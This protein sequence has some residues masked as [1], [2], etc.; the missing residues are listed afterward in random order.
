MKRLAIVAYS[1][2][3]LK[4]YCDLFRRTLKDYVTI[5]GYC[6]EDGSVYTEIDADLVL[7]SSDDMFQIARKQ[8]LPDTRIVRANL[9]FSRKGYE[10]IQALPK[11]TKALLVNVNMNLSLQCVEQL[12]HLGIRDIELIPYAPYVE[13]KEKAEVAISPGERWSVPVYVKKIIEVG[14]RQIDIATVVY[15]LVTMD[16]GFL[17]QSPAIQAYCREIIPANYGSTYQYIDEHRGKDE[18]ESRGLITFN[19]V[20]KIKTYNALAKEIFGIQGEEMVG[21]DV[22]RLFPKEEIRQSVMNMKPGQ[23]KRYQIQGREVLI[24]LYLERFQQDGVLNYM[25]AE[26]VPEGK[27]KHRVPGRGYTAKYWFPDIITQSERMKNLLDLAEKNAKSESSILICGESGTGKELLAQ[28]IHNG[29]S[30]KNRPFVGLNCASLPESLLESELFGYE[31][32]AF[33]GAVRGGKRGLF[34]QANTG[35]LFLDEIGEMPIHLQTRLLRVL[36]EKE[37][38]R[39]GGE[40]VIDVDVRIIAATNRNLKQQLE[41]GSFRRDLYYRLNVIPLKLPALRERPEDIPLLIDTFLRQLGVSYRFTPE[42]MDFLQTYRWEGNIRELRNCVEYFSNWNQEEISRKDLDSLFEPEEEE[43][44]KQEERP[45]EAFLDFVLH[46]KQEAALSFLVL[47]QIRLRAAQGQA[48]G[49]RSL[50]DEPALKSQGCTEAKLRGVL[51]E[52]ERFGLLE[53]S[54]GRGGTSLTEKGWEMAELLKGYLKTQ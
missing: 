2:S 11:G 44:G 10:A 38:M 18:V 20:G 3:A 31:E 52:L 29:S 41:E 47:E 15:V 27:V 49:R 40:C 45:P 19:G 50:V 1:K 34:E 7:V 32:G 36:Q 21:E 54:R 28:S 22:I 30:R 46:T 24:Q 6:M 23:K 17:F 12:Y 26:Y 43:T 39:I 16:L 9:T 13:V 5:C 51:Q 4:D 53:T 8:V 14:K 25:T 37:I 33:T 35:T 42:A 48:A